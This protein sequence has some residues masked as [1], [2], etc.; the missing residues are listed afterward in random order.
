MLT[1]TIDLRALRQRL[2]ELGC[3]TE[4]WQGQV[5][6]TGSGEGLGQQRCSAVFLPDGC[7]VCWHM[8]QET[9]RKVLR[10]AASYPARSRYAATA[11]GFQHSPRSR[12][13]QLGLGKPTASEKLEVQ[14]APAGV[15]TA[16][17][18]EDG[19]VRLTRDTYAR[20]SDQLGISLGLAV[21]VR[22]EALENKIEARLEADW[23]KLNRDSDSN[24]NLSAVSDR[25]FIAEKGLHKLRYELNS[26]RSLLDASDLVWEHSFAE[27]LYDQVGAHFD[28]RRRTETLNNR[29]SYSLDYLHTLGEHVRHGYSGR[30][31]RIIIYLIFIEICLAMADHLPSVAA[32]I[33]GPDKSPPDAEDEW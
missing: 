33:A 18:R 8:S 23:D 20:A 13:D 14:D 19:L 10:L 2:V 17:A 4:L 29:M 25:I 21:A 32:L 9:E 11:P 16:L 27:R 30:L 5:L 28:V 7:V 15:V 12:M 31:E 22:L 26:D 3:P 6:L 24:W 1:G